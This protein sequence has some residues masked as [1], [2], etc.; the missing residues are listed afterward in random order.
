MTNTERNR[1]GARLIIWSKPWDKSHHTNDEVYCW[2]A[3]DT[4]KNEIAAARSASHDARVAER[5]RIQKELDE[6]LQCV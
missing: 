1:L 6:S 4:I 5:A 3:H 2:L